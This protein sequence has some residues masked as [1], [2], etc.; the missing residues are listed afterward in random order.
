MARTLQEVL[1]ER[2]EKLADIR[3]RYSDDVVRESALGAEN[4]AEMRAEAQDLNRRICAVCDEYRAEIADAENYERQ[5]V[6]C[7][8]PS[9]FDEFISECSEEQKKEWWGCA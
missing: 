4:R 1:S 5:W 7:C 8:N 6:D 2:D 3:A 9:R